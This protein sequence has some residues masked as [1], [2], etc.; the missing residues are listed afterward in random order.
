[1]NKKGTKEQKTNKGTEN[2]Q[3]ANKGTNKRKNDQLID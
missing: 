1:M 3:K 2:E